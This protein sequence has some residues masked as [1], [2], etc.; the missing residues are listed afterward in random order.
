MRP[1]SANINLITTLALPGGHCDKRRIRNIPLEWSQSRG[2]LLVATHVV[3]DRKPRLVE[4]DRPGTACVK[5][6]K[7]IIKIILAESN[8]GDHYAVAF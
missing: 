1:L 6:K 5:S 8:K 2:A 3:S 7:Y 4:T